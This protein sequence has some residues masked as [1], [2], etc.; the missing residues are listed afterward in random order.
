MG[1][2]PTS[3]KQ[4]F[5]NSLRSYQRLLVSRFRF[6]EVIDLQNAYVR[7]PNKLNSGEYVQNKFIKIQVIWNQIDE[8]LQALLDNQ[9][10]GDSGKR[11][12]TVT[13]GHLIR[14]HIV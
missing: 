7:K 5:R 11:L 4:R 1:R 2:D 3:L 10:L 8:L 12:L 9:V 14:L 6:D 13:N